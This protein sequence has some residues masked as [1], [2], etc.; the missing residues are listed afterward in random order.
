MGIGQSPY[1]PFG[2]IGVVRDSLTISWVSSNKDVYGMLANEVGLLTG[3]P[4][5][6]N[7][8]GSTLSLF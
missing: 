6:W 1:S 5:A 3:G 7:K 4:D 8:F 2:L